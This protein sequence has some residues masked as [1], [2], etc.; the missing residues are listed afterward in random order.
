MAEVRPTVGG[1][2]IHHAANASARSGQSDRNDSGR[3]RSACR[4]SDVHSAAITCVWL[5]QRAIPSRTPTDSA[6]YARLALKAPAIFWR[7]GTAFDFRYGVRP[8][9]R[10][11]RRSGP[12]VRRIGSAGRARRFHWRSHG[13]ATAAP[14]SQPLPSG[15]HPRQG[16]LAHLGGGG[17]RSVRSRC[18][19]QAREP[20]SAPLPWTHCV[21]LRLG[22]RHRS[23]HRLAARAH[24][25]SSAEPGERRGA[26]GPIRSA[27]DG[28][29]Q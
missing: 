19:G 5:D 6:R 12:P 23:I 1:R 14:P 8:P 16:L 18:A 3:R 22:I 29:H 15:R 10:H 24:A 25:P 21:L 2:P 17:H 26:C 28:Q 4:T 9:C 13:I 11:P 7:S 27:S 20:T